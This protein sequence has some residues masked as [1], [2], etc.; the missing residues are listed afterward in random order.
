LRMSRVTEEQLQQLNI[1]YPLSERSK[2]LFRVVSEFQEPFDEDDSLDEE[3]ARV[4]FDLESND[5][6]DDYEMGKDSFT[7]TDDED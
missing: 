7:P 6:G 4:E 1:Y 2:A 5:N 3:Q